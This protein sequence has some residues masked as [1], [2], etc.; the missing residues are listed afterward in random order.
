MSLRANQLPLFSNRTSKYKKRQHPRQNGTREE[1]AIESQEKM[2]WCAKR[3]FSDAKQ[4]CGG[5]QLSHQ[6]ERLTANS[7]HSQQIQNTQ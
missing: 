4:M 7:N 3:D 6:N 2:F 1:N 5:L